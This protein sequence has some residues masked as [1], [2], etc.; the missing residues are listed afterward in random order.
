MTVSPVGGEPEPMAGERVIGP[1]A[2]GMAP[3][4]FLTPS[5]RLTF[6]PD[7]K[8]LTYSIA[9]RSQN[10]WLAEGLGAPARKR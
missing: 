3:S 5:L 4:T 2:Q 1:I 9:K 10:L 6:A 7:G 8:S